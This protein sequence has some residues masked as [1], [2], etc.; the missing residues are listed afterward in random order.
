MSDGDDEYRDALHRATELITNA[1]G[2]IGAGRRTNAQMVRASEIA[3]VELIAIEIRDGGRRPGAF[4]KHPAHLPDD[5]DEMH[6]LYSSTMGKDRALRADLVEWRAINRR[7]AYD[8][9]G[10][11]RSLIQAYQLARHLLESSNDEAEK[12]RLF[13]W[14]VAILNYAARAFRV[15]CE[16]APSAPDAL[17]VWC[18]EMTNR[19]NPVPE[20][21]QKDMRPGEERKKTKP[22]SFLGRVVANE[23]GDVINLDER[24]RRRE[25]T[26]RDDDV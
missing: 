20:W 10:A 7:V 24:R 21:F 4:L 8:A 16:K 19:D 5:D 22:I 17:E 11:L 1:H 3:M 9:I 25:E 13:Q 18:R 15:D 12:D 26:D 6:T 14:Q 23:Q 2:P